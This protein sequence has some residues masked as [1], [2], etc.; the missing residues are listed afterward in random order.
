MNIRESKIIKNLWIAFLIVAVFWPLAFIN[1]G[2]DFL[3]TGYYLANYANILKMPEK[4]GIGTFLSSYFGGLIYSVIPSHHLMVF[5][6]LNMLFNGISILLAFLVMKEY[7]N[8]NLLSFFTMIA[9]FLLS[10]YPLCLSYNTFSVLLLSV[11]VFILHK[12]FYE[13]KGYLL[14][15]FGTIIG[16]SVFFRLP[17]ILFALLCSSVFWIDTLTEQKKDIIH[18]AVKVL[19]GGILGFAMGLTIVL[20]LIGPSQFIKSM[21]YF[22]N[23]ATGSND[24]H[25]ILRTIMT[26][27]HSILSMAHK[28]LF[29][30]AFSIIF[31]LVLPNIIYKYRTMKKDKHFKLMLALFI[32]TLIVAFC[33]TEI[34]FH[35][36]ITSV[37]MTASLVISVSAF[38]IWYYRKNDI[39]FSAISMCILVIS[40]VITLGTDNAFAQH[41]VVCF[42]LLPYAILTFCNLIKE[43]YYNEPNRLNSVIVS[44]FIIILIYVSGSNIYNATTL[45]YIKQYGESYKETVAMPN[46]KYLA[47]VKT[48]K[49]K[50]VAID[51]I[52]E[53]MKN[54]KY[55]GKKI[56]AMNHIPI[57]YALLDN[58]NL[59]G[60]SF[61]PDLESVPMSKIRTNL[62]ESE[63]NND[64]P[65]IIIYDPPRDDSALGEKLSYVREFCERM[66]YTV[67]DK[68]ILN[69]EKIYTILVP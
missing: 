61:W 40:I 38:S 36:I 60:A 22:S 67:A 7:F 8:R 19:I 52:T 34:K 63:K 66:N 56:L 39:N 54:D 45:T 50:V 25:S 29:Y 17:N 46:N 62:E 1:K 4:F 12:W 11:A 18:D 41:T 58:E 16:F 28:H 35:E 37:L 42:W 10:R 23:V 57:I 48:T 2:I 33:L 21:L 44:C 47:G 59:L 20:V 27:G 6:L 31:L 30:M 32:L 5:K 13:R 68:G 65:V 53:F 15:V 9:S 14:I 49:E 26:I 3:D 64:L 51:G 55:K 43:L 24:S 69:G